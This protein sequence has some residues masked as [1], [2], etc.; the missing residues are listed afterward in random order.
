MFFSILKSDHGKAYSELEDW[1][2]HF[3]QVRD[4][5]ILYLLLAKPKYIVHHA[6]KLNR[7]A[8]SLLSPQQ[9]RS[10]MIHG[11][12]TENEEETERWLAIFAI[13][14]FPQRAERTAKS[15]VCTA[16]VCTALTVNVARACMHA[17]GCIR[18]AVQEECRW[19]CVY[20]CDW[21][22]TGWKACSN[23]T[24]RPQSVC[25]PGL[26]R[27][28]HDV[29]AVCSVCW[30]CINRRDQKQTVRVRVDS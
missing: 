17:H 7:R 15:V 11:V 22:L 30:S 23:T 16:H 28:A 1:K 25:A 21:S 4:P 2:N 13:S 24:C 14:S 5:W 9:F 27:L 8:T 29:R 3:F 20:V 12:D 19:L 10:L 6:D 26:R 18:Y